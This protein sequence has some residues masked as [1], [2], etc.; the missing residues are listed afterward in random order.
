[1]IFFFQEFRTWS[2]GVLQN[3]HVCGCEA[4]VRSRFLYETNHFNTDI[5]QM[6]PASLYW[7]VGINTPVQSF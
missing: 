4:K 3:I 6:V 7:Q 5:L 1:M 2:K